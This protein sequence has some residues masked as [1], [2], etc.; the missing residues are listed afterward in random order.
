MIHLVMG[1]TM[2]CICGVCV[3]AFLPP[4]A[5]A[6]EYLRTITHASTELDSHSEAAARGRSRNTCRTPVLSCGVV[7]EVC[8]PLATPPAFCRVQERVSSGVHAQAGGIPLPAHPPRSSSRVPVQNP[9]SRP[10]QR[11]TKSMPPR[12]RTARRCAQAA[13]RKLSVIQSVHAS[14]G[15]IQDTPQCCVNYI[16]GVV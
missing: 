3:R 6:D 2:S 12:P 11:R 13:R 1:L 10:P 16:G 15:R 9:L 4:G 8:A 5:A 7:I 14:R